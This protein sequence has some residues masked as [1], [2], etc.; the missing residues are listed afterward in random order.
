LFVTGRQSVLKRLA[1]QIG[2]ALVERDLQRLIFSSS[3]DAGD[4]LSKGG[5]G[6]V[7]LCAVHFHKCYRFKR[8]F[9]EF[10][11]RQPRYLDNL[12]RNGYDGVVFPFVAIDGGGAMDLYVG[13]PGVSY[14]PLYLLEYHHESSAASFSSSIATSSSS[15]S[16]YM[17]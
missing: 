12:K 16:S 6:V 1:E 15:I 13:L 10:M 8:S 17:L 4:A 2:D 14:V 7:L 11:R 3:V 9:R 5:H